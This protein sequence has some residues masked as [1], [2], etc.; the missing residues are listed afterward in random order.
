MQ[1]NYLAGVV[2][3]IRSIRRVDPNRSRCPSR[4]WRS[5]EAS[6]KSSGGLG[7][8]GIRVGA[9]VSR[10]PFSPS[11]GRLPIGYPARF[12]ISA[13]RLMMQELVGR[14]SRIF[15]FLLK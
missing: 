11:R 15:F 14:G 12:V 6:E 1:E 9:C 4:Y 2:Y 3:S 13:G 7:C 8:P 5:L 10:R